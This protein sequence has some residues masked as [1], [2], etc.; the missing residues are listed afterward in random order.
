MLSF[1]ML[2]KDNFPHIYAHEADVA[3]WN[4]TFDFSVDF[5]LDY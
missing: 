2:L 4:E 1:K 3:C 5:I